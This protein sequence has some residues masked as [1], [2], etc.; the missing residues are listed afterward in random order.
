MT[1]TE[2]A[3]QEALSGIRQSLQ[4]DGY[5]LEVTGFES[6]VLRV[7]VRALDGACEDCLVPPSAME[8]M[9]K[10]AMPSDIR[11]ERVELTYP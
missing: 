7:G 11:V 8:T 2:I 10:A 4:V 1:S 9:I 6:A 3:A 5:D